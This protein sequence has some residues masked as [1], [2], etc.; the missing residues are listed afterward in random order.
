M[1][2][3]LRNSGWRIQWIPWS[4]PD[5]PEIIN[6]KKPLA[7][8]GVVIFLGAIFWNQWSYF[9]VTLSVN[10]IIIIAVSGLAVAML[11]IISS[12][13]HIQSGWKRI[14]AHCIDREIC[15]Y[16][17]E[18]GDITSAWG[19]RLICIFNYKGKEYKVTPEPSHLV[20]FDSKQQIENF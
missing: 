4:S 12:T 17:K 3:N 20:S 1:Q 19:Y 2:D 15:E 18:P 6:S 9:G 10:Q 5:K 11:G 13:F 14:E 7:L 8:I 16:Q